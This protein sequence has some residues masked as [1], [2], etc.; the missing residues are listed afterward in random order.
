MIPGSRKPRQNEAM[1]G[2][3]SSHGNE[4]IPNHPAAVSSKNWLLRS[5]IPLLNTFATS[6]DSWGSQKV[7]NRSK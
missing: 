4:I 7:K 6:N 1:G 3:L 5:S 2:L